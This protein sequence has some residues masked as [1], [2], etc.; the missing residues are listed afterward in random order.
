M[1]NGREKGTG[2][3]VNILLQHASYTKARFYS[4]SPT[5]PCVLWCARCVP[6]QA[7]T[8]P[9]L[10]L[11]YQTPAP[12]LHYSY[13][14]VLWCTLCVPMQALKY[15][16]LY[17]IYHTFSPLLHLSYSSLCV[18]VYP[19]CSDAGTDTPCS[20]PHIPKPV[21]APPLLLLLICYVVLCVF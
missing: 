19:V 5:L 14:C 16:V 2:K 17:L 13:S 18:M 1:N 15:P 9:V 8:Y 7:L 11:I 21:S 4:T 6:M 20:P 10:H 3:R 12:V